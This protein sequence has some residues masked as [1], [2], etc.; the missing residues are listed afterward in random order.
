MEEA[1]RRVREWV[2]GTRLDLSRLDLTELP[3]LPVNLKE[4]HITRNKLTKLPENLP[5]GLTTLICTLNL[6]TELP[7]ALP[8]SL[9]I[10]WCDS[11]NITS[12]PESLPDSLTD[13]N[14]S[15]NKLT[16]LPNNFPK[17]LTDL[18]CSNNEITVIPENLPTSLKVLLI[19]NNKITV[20]PENLPASLYGLNCSK[21]KITVIP[22]NLPKTLKDLEVSHNS[23]LRLP[24]KLPPL[25]RTFACGNTDLIKLPDKLP[26]RLV[27]LYCNNN[28]LTKLPEKLPS[29]IDILECKNNLLEQLPEK[30]PESLLVLVCSNNKL[31]KLPENLPE[32]LEVLFCN[33]NP[34]TKIPHFPQFLNEIDLTNTGILHIK[35]KRGKTLGELTSLTESDRLS[36]Y[37]HESV[38]KLVDKINNA[39]YGSRKGVNSITANEDVDVYDIHEHP[40]DGGITRESLE[41]YMKSQK[42]D[43]EGDGLNKKIPC[44]YFFG[45][46]RCAYPIVAN[47]VKH[48]VSPQF[49]N[50]FY[51]P[52]D[53]NVSVNQGTFPLI[54]TNTVKNKNYMNNGKPNNSFPPSYHHTICPYC[55]VSDERT[56]GCSYMSHICKEY[57]QVKELAD[58]YRKAVTADGKL[59][60]CVVCGRP[61]TGHQHLTNDDPPVRIPHTGGQANLFTK[62]DG[63]GRP[64]MFARLL[65]IRQ[66]LKENEGDEDKF[67]IRRR[68]ALAADSA[69][70]NTELMARGEQLAAIEA[71][72]RSFNKVEGGRRRTRRK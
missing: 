37:S 69:Y 65:A 54:L 23:H 8:S 16:S 28:N 14:I 55:L 10:I 59:E 66:V 21:N 68:C 35:V 25:L 45:T 17:S 57:N 38:R 15:H 39:I 61:S 30:L 67:E 9:Q 46:K 7:S 58:K 56:H 62:C 31:S 33:N 6:I 36:Y 29:S 44:Y 26:N 34:L 2:E 1:Q 48:I 5:N 41:A 60:W 12:L 20:I 47:D 70:K 11:N 13:I 64:E 72:E 53:V 22:D 51:L 4:L 42:F 71:G 24:D 19:A 32:S 40:D 18:R 3:E 43:A 63:G 50:W 52:S 49:F 27:E